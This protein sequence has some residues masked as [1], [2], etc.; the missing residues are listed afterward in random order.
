MT[1]KEYL[2]QTFTLLKLIKAKEEQIQQ[3]RDMLES[4]TGGIQTSTK[5]QSSL[6][7]DSISEITARILD[8]EKECQQGISQMLSILREIGS[9]IENVSQ[10]DCR[11]ILYERYVNGKRWNDIAVDNNYSLKWVHVLHNRGLTAIEQDHIC[12]HRRV[13]PTYG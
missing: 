12:Q 10:V 7:T 6:R 5:V 2:S 11:L 8:A 1:A 4:T 3:L 13:Q 9:A